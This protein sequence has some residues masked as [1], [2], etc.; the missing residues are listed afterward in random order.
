VQYFR[1][2]TG[3][4]IKEK[5]VTH[6]GSTL[7]HVDIV[8]DVINLLPIYWIADKLVRLYLSRV[9]SLTINHRFLF[10]FVSSL[11]SR[12]R[13]KAILAGFTDTKSYTNNLP[14]SASESESIIVRIIISYV[15]SYVF[16]NL[17]T[18]NDWTLRTRAHKTTDQ[19]TE[20]IKEHLTRLSSGIVSLVCSLLLSSYRISNSA[21]SQRIS[22]IIDRP[23]CRE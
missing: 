1:D 15:I 14:T 5:S 11:A 23:L 22:P 20:H 9:F 13:R 16:M 18:A 12:P 3:A 17:D 10:F 7:M 8:K 6:A 2:I 19:F 21:L 4:L